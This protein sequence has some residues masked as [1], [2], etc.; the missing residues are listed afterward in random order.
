MLNTW[1]FPPTDKP[2]PSI[3]PTF[4]GRLRQ[5]IQNESDQELRTATLYLLMQRTELIQSAEAFAHGHISSDQLHD[6]VISARITTTKRFSVPSEEI[7]ALLQKH[8]A[9]A[10]SAR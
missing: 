1:Q 3:N 6:S 2:L 4:F 5:H 10:L 7:T 9:Q 8:A